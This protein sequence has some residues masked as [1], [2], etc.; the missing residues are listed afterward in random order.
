MIRLLP[1]R[2][3]APLSRDERQAEL[4]A[5]QPGRLLELAEATGNRAL[6]AVAWGMLH[7]GRKQQRGS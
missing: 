2:R 7:R 3:E 4:Y 5:D 1:N 6:R